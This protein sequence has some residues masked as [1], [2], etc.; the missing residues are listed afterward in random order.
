MT[1]EQKVAIQSHMQAIAEILYEDT[2]PEQLETLEDIETGIRT[3]LLEHIGP[4]LTLFLSAA[5]LAQP[6]GA[7]EN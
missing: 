6:K 1:P 3:Q 2:P 5:V 7:N 4:E